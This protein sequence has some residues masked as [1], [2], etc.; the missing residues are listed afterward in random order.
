LETLRGGIEAEVNFSGA[1]SAMLFLAKHGACLLAVNILHTVAVPVAKRA[2]IR[3][4][5]GYVMAN[6]L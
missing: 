5:P 4:A 1:I 3:Y 6:V 2:L